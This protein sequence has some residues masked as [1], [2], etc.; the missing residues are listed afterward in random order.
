MEVSPV[1]NLYCG[2][3]IE[4]VRTGRLSYH[5]DARCRCAT[6]R[7]F[8]FSPVPFIHLSLVRVLDGRFLQGTP[9]RVQHSTVSSSLFQYIRYARPN[10]RWSPSPTPPFT[11]RFHC[12]HEQSSRHFKPDRHPEPYAYIKRRRLLYVFHHAGSLSTVR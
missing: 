4:P 9:T 12:I 6:K 7:E 11:R 1:R 2:R 8:F 10:D 3:K 5:D